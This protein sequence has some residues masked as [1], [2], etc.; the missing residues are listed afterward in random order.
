MNEGLEERPQVIDAPADEA[1][2]CLVQNVFNQLG[3]TGNILEDQDA[4]GIFL[5]LQFTFLES[6]QCHYA[7]IRRAVY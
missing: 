3:I 1:D 5:H 2:P 4:D 6:E 7:R